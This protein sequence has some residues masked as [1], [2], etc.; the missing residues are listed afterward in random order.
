MREVTLVVVMVVVSVVGT[1][2]VVVMVVVS[3]GGGDGGD[4]GELACMQMLLA[5]FQGMCHGTRPK[6]LCSGAWRKVR[7]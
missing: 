4:K 1:T 2:A 3:R 5:G 7:F 6:W